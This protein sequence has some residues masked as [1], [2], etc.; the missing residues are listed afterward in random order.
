MDD[1]VLLSHSWKVHPDHEI[2]MK[3]PS[4]GARLAVERCLGET[5]PF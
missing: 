2:T 1:L 3:S 4:L 5:S